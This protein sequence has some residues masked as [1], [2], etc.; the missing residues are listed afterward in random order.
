MH[1]APYP[2]RWGEGTVLQQRR[3]HPSGPGTAWGLEVGDGVP[4]GPAE[5]KGTWPGA[6]TLLL[7][8]RPP[9]S[10]GSARLGTG[11]QSSS[12]RQLTPRRGVSLSI[13][14]P[15]SLDPETGGPGLPGK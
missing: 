11:D 6:W 8:G 13:Q 2:A 12:P 14:G 15:S 7:A 4:G 1:P 10:V 3:L 9:G 5:L